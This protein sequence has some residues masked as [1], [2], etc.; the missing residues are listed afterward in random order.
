MKV[1]R[2]DDCCPREEGGVGLRKLKEVVEVASLKLIWRFLTKSGFL[3]VNWVQK[4]LVDGPWNWRKLL[5]YRPIAQ[6][7]IQSEIRDG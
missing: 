6:T 7:F 2:E 3:W 4:Y 5:K 1:E